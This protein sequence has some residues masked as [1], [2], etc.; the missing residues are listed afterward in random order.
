[1][2]ANVEIASAV[3]AQFLLHLKERCIKHFFKCILPAIG[4]DIVHLFDSRLAGIDAKIEPFA[5]FIFIYR[6][7]RLVILFFACEQF[8]LFIDIFDVKI[9]LDLL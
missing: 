6:F 9:F 7:I 1:V 3:L 2:I 4:H 5:C 8:V